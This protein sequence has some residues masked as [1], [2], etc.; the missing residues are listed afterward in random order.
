MNIIY[1]SVISNLHQN[2][3][4]FIQSFQNHFLYLEEWLLKL[5]DFFC[6][7]LMDFFCGLKCSEASG[8][9]WYSLSL[10]LFL[11][12]KVIITIR[13]QYYELPWSIQNFR[14]ILKILWLHLSTSVTNKNQFLNG[15][16]IRK[17]DFDI[18]IEFSHLQ[19]YR[20]H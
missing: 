1:K 7:D 4:S 5:K 2:T 16:P 17:K 14:I 11:K 18:Y 3:F 6:F 10:V 9:W 12:S 15:H 19:S 20:E 8:D 13:Y